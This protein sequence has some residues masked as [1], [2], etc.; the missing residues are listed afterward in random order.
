MT[1]PEEQCVGGAVSRPGWKRSETPA[2]RAVVPRLEPL[3]DDWARVKELARAVLDGVREGEQ[4]RQ[5]RVDL[6]TQAVMLG[7]K[8]GDD[9]TKGFVDFITIG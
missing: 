5:C 8:P 4:S 6:H 1:G 9:F 7:A 2:D 3:V